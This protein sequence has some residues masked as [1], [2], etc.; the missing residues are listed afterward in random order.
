[1]GFGV[2]LLMSYV[3]AHFV[4]L[5]AVSMNMALETAF[6]TWLGFIVTVSFNS[7]IWCERAKAS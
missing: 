5:N 6:W 7:M 3:L 2:S 1:M 4:A